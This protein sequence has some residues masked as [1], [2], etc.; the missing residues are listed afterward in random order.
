[1]QN[2]KLWEWK[3]MYLIHTVLLSIYNKLLIAVAH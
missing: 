3:N 2:A 1:M